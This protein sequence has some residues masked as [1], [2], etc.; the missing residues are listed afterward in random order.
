MNPVLIGG[1]WPYANGS[2]HV[3]QIAALLP[4][5]VLARYFRL[6][7]H[8][9]LYVSGTD[10]HGTPITVRADRE[11]V[12]PRQIADRYHHEFKEVFTRLGFSFDCYSRTDSPQHR[13]LVQSVFLQLWHSG[14]LDKRT[15]SQ[16]YCPS[17]SRFLPDRYV[18]GRCPH[19]GAAARGDQC[20]ACT[21]LLN[22]EDLLDPACQLCG[23]KTQLRDSEHFYLRLSAFQAMLTAQ[24]EQN[25][26]QYRHNARQ[27]TARYLREGLQDR[28]ITRDLDWGI[29]VPLPGYENKKIYVWVDAVLGYLS[30]SQAWAEQNDGDWH[31]F[32]A[33][34]AQAWYVHGKD[35]IVFHTL[36]LPALLA[37]Y[38]PDLKRPDH[39]VSSGYMTLEGQK[40]STSRNWAVWAADLLDRFPAD[41]IRYFLISNNPEKRDADF[42]LPSFLASHNGELLG[43]FGNF[44]YR[45]FAFVKQYR[46]GVTPN[47][48]C[49]PAIR[50]AIE[51]TYRDCDALLT[52]AQIKKALERVFELV[53]ALNRYFDQCQ[54][55]RTRHDDPDACD[56][57]IATSL[58]G[59]VNLAQLLDP[60]LPF[61]CARIR[62]DL[63]IA[64]VA[65]WAYLDCP[66]GRIIADPAPLYPRF[67]TNKPQAGTGGSGE[68]RVKR[69][70]HAPDGLVFRRVKV[71][72]NKAG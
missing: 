13:R 67:D 72:D 7:G 49:D 59:I 68:A 60:Y 51:Q 45:T 4:A 53:R 28:A 31:R 66:C 40:I 24:L 32:W 5:D 1:A 29:P 64:E 33:Q 50:S 11:K 9:V 25:Q 8:P 52:G 56:R 61:S 19:C 69:A 43:A 63:G 48:P 70:G 20:D 3:G 22:P 27:E 62:Q 54:P 10:C 16:V 15:V 71:C 47:E 65:G 57:A 42:S 37:G 38:D 21:S 36:I 39:I 46:D 34:D 44:V 41:S 2:L 23:Q 12:S 18:I 6:K 55:W 58:H 14:L 30:A 17:C 35:N 26:D